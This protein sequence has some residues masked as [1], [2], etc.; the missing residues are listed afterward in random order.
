MTITNNTNPNKPTEVAVAN[1]TIAGVNKHL[2]NN[3]SL[4]IA[5]EAFTP[6]TLT[7]VFQE[8]IA[9]IGEADA[10]KTTWRQKVADAKAAKTRA[11]AVRKALKRYL[12]GTFG[13][14]AVGVLE[15]FGFTV[16]KAPGRKTVA[17]KAQ[18]VVQAKATRDARHT[19]GKVQRKA[20]K[21][22]PA[23]A[24]TPPPVVTPS[25]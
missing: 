12:L 17:S 9:A 10:S 4:P 21:G 25:K 15:D 23:A 14:G 13:D 11:R 19:M 5:G 22:K 6:V 24:P 3:T 2:A 1:Q 7:A 8:E 16:P 20:V 18:A